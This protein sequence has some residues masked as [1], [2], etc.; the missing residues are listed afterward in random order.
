MTRKP[1]AFGFV[2][3]VCMYQGYAYIHIHTYTY[4]L[5]EVTEA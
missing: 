5:G 1:D 4:T 3:S 2:T